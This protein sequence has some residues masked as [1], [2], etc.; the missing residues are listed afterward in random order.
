[1]PRVAAGVFLAGGGIIFQPRVLSVGCLPAALLR[2]HSVQAFLLRPIQRLF[3]A[4]SPFLPPRLPG[5][6][7]NLQSSA[8][9]SISNHTPS[10]H[11]ATFHLFNIISFLFFLHL[12]FYFHSCL[13]HKN[14]CV[15]K[16][17]CSLGAL[18]LI[19]HNNAS[20]IIWRRLKFC[21]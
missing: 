17:F 19:F 6:L 21:S 20:N 3:F 11:H 13:F 12:L 14:Y 1:M 15:I 8:G 2:P 18:L 9:T 5:P 4:I 16:T 7:P 10:H